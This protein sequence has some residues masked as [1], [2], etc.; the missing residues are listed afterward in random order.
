MQPSW[1]NKLMIDNL[2]TSESVH[3]NQLCVHIPYVFI[4]QYLCALY[5]TYIYVLACIPDQLLSFGAL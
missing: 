5:Y 4:Q 2:I 3:L 1:I